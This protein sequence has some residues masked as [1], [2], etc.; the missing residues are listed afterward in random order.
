MTGIHPTKQ[1]IAL[2]TGSNKGIGFELVKQLAQAGVTTV[3]SARTELAGQQACH[4]LHSIGLQISFIQLDV[5]DPTCI[6]E[7][8]EHLRSCYGKLDILVNNAGILPD[9]DSEASGLTVS[10]DVVRR[11]F[12]TNTLGPLQVSQ[13][14]IPL[15]RLSPAGRIINI[16]SGMGSL[17]DMDGGYPAYR[18]SKTALNAVTRILAGELAN[19]NI[20]VNSVCPGWVKTDMGGPNAERT[21][22]Q[23]VAGI[24][25]L[26]LSEDTRF[27]GQFLRD[28]KPIPW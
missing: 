23:S 16:S 4:Q 7:A 14:M 26:L 2:V 21:P 18:I 6:A 5:T 24:L 10:P 17:S 12:E 19:T 9:A 15:L 27:N 11:V 22:A 1:R 13:A 3:L 8:A 28:G 20:T 25:P